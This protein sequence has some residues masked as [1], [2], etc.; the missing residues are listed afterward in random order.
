MWEQFR[1]AEWRVWHCVSHESGSALRARL[2][3]YVSVFFKCLKVRLE[4]SF[5]N[6]SMFL[7]TWTERMENLQDIYENLQC[8]FPHASNPEWLLPFML[9]YSIT[10]SLYDAKAQ[11]YQYELVKKNW[12]PTMEDTKQLLR[13][14]CDKHAHKQQAS[15]SND[16]NS[17]SRCTNHGGGNCG[18]HKGGAVCQIEGCSIGLYELRW[19]I[20]GA[21]YFIPPS[22]RNIF[23]IGTVCSLRI[24]F[25]RKT[26]DCC[27][28]A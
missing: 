14:I 26:D 4:P 27:V 25:S 24:I 10:L 22:V 1:K 13:L 12:A 6:V 21:R 2:I 19:S 20:N 16:N 17:T 11:T 3:E 5:D 9:V 18:S 7:K 28:N 15:I 23:Y 8:Q